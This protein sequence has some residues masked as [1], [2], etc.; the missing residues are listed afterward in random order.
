MLE[1]NIKKKLP[2][3]D[4]EV[5]FSA[6]SGIMA[7]L[8]PSGSGKTMTLQCVAGLTQVDEGYINLNGE[9]LLDTSRKIDIRPQV[10]RVGF[11]FQNYALF[12]H[13]TVRDN[14]AY[15]IRHLEKAE[16]DGIITRLMENMHIA[17]LGHR[18]PSQLS[19]GQQ[20]RVALARAIAPEPR[21]LLLDEPFSALDAV[22]KESLEIELLSLQ[23]FYKGI[24]I[25]VTHNFA[26][27]Y[28]MSSKMAIYESGRIA[29]CGDKGK[30]VGSPAN[31]TVAGLMGFKNLLVGTVRQIIGQDL[32][33]EVPGLSLFKIRLPEQMQLAV[34][35]RLT[36]G[37]RSE[38]VRVSAASEENS[39]PGVVSGVINEVASTRC[40]FSAGA[41]LQYT[42]EAFLPPPADA[43]LKV[44]SRL[45][46]CFPPEHLVVVGQAGETAQTG[47]LAG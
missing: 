5:A 44:G 43:S 38:F 2:G 4:L 32:Y 11:V 25:L 27:G 42:F 10:R 20:Q 30:I 21:V 31:L 24:I 7:M 45:N 23:Q 36:L 12:P 34:G 41:N 17:S 47:S 8:G 22:V 19:A 16:S 40:F 18:F 1:V 6:D 39:L 15:G 35:M 3:F 13:L 26:E 28:R 9:V 29:Q 37:I 33:L 46:F 14:I